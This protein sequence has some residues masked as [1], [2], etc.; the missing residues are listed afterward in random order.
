MERKQGYV[1]GYATA[2]VKS[3]PT[4]GSG[5]FTALVSTFGGEPDLQGDVVDPHAFDDAIKFWRGRGDWP[6]LLWQHDD[7]NPANV[8]GKVVEMRATKEG[9]V[10]DGQLNLKNERAVSLYEAVL[11]GSIN[12]FSIG[13]AYEKQD[14]VEQEDGSYL[15]TKVEVLEVSF[16]VAGANRNTRV[17]EIKQASRRTVQGGP[18]SGTPRSYGGMTHVKMVSLDLASSEE[19][20]I[21][22]RTALREFGPTDDVC[23]WAAQIDDLQNEERAAGKR[24]LAARVE[25]AEELL[26]AEKAEAEARAKS[27]AEW[28]ERT[29]VRGPFPRV[30]ARMRPV[31]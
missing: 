11:D 2:T 19:Q 29:L 31:E 13:Y 14:R 10:V 17:L 6:P 21:L 23:A 24:T 27:D 3:A 9:L 26:K 28:R 22:W 1:Y 20:W 16:V 30:D 4:D 15:L 12:Q 25:E 18:G 5:R 8:V 7:S